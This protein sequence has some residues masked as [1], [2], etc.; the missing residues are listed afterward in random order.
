MSN[1]YLTSDLH[2]GHEASIEFDQRPFRNLH[3]MHDVLVNNFNSTVRT[4][5]TTFFLG[6]VGFGGDIT[7]E[8]LLSLNGQKILIRGNH[9]KKGSEFWYKCGFASVM[10]F[11][12]ITVAGELVTMSHCPL[13]GVF[14]EDVTGM[15]G[16]VEG[17]NWHGER[18]HVGRFTVPNFGQFHCHGHIHSG[19]HRED[20][21]T[22]LDRQMDVGVVANKY[23]PVGI[24]RINQFIS[25]QK[26]IEGII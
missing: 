21:R 24:D 5:D 8:I 14:R 23:R 25:L 3:H 4:C 16:A 12:A 18:K 15:K 9:D 7:K 17:E 13:P 11:G 19:P 22:I 10:N 20:K 2:I 6:D 26:K 1:I